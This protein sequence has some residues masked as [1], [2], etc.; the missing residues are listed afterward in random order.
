MI[1]YLVSIHSLLIITVMIYVSCTSSLMMVPNTLIRK[2]T[3]SFI[4]M[5][6]EGPEVLTAVDSMNIFFTPPPIKPDFPSTSIGNK[7]VLTNTTF[8]SGR[9]KRGEPTNWNH[10]KPKLP[11]SLVDIKCKGKFIYFNLIDNTSIW[12]TLGL[13]GHWSF[14]S[15]YSDHVRFSLDFLNTQTKE[16]CK[17]YYYD[18]IS[19]GT[20]KYCNDSID[21]QKKLKQLGVCWLNDDPTFDDFY[22]IAM[23][24]KS[25]RP[26]VLFLMDQKKMS[27]VGNYILS[28]VLYRSKI[29][30][31]VTCGEIQD[32]SD[33][34]DIYSSIKSVINHSY[35]S[36]T[37][38]SQLKHVQ[39]GS[40]RFHFYVY[41]KRIC[42]LGYAVVRI[43]GAHK[44][45]I[46]YVKEVQTKYKKD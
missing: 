43:E 14:S 46:H 37:P 26:L 35:H 44:R 16:T 6:P 17:L 19:Y 21:L 20:L 10:L 1:K 41:S 15:K 5:M 24:Q 22:T 29:Y 12:S 31:S 32:K 2:Y 23:K 27:G 36:Q 33:W 42:P 4:K 9:Y 39:A 38:Y 13:S 30:P 11:I 8:I 34:Y 28:E 40:D 7:W 45:T 18:Q 25:T 3:K